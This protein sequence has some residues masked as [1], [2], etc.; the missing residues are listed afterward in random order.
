MLLGPDT[1]NLSNG[2]AI[3]YSCCCR[4]QGKGKRKHSKYESFR[5]LVDHRN[6][7]CIGTEEGGGDR[8][9]GGV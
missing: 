9:R 8:A 1:S 2:D 6:Q 7:T 4:T 5:Y 3:E